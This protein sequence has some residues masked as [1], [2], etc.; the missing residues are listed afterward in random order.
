MNK[1]PYD[2]EELICPT[3]KHRWVFVSSKEITDFQHNI[4]IGYV[5]SQH[6]LIMKENNGGKK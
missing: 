2:K 5:K 4:W 3:C 1:E 6:E